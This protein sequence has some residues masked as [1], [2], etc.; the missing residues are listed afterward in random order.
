MIV[1]G[2]MMADKW[3]RIFYQ[4]ALV[5]LCILLPSALIV[6]GCSSQS[7]QVPSLRE[8][9]KAFPVTQDRSWIVAP[10]LKGDEYGLLSYLPFEEYT[11]SNGIPSLTNAMKDIADT[12]HDVT[13]I[14]SAS[15]STVTP[16]VK[17][18]RAVQDIQFNYSLNNDKIILTPTIAAKY[19][20]NVTLDVTVEGVKDKNGN[21]QQ[22][23]KTWIAYIDKNQ[24]VWGNDVFT[25]DKKLNDP[26]T[27][28]TT[29]ANKGGATKQ[30][31]IDNIPSWMTVTPTS[32]IIAP[33]SVLPIKI[34]LDEN[35]A[36]GNYENDL[37]LLTDFG[38]AEKCKQAKLLNNL[39][40]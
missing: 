38:F 20:E 9:P 10:P 35:M 2:I 34:D 11:V 21:Y 29:I 4:R 27:I 8:A 6:G 39:F 19:I 17:L 13:P 33:N 25:L 24:V 26:L 22:S 3:G 7:S 5:C 36:I 18:P 12:S 32:G 14:N 15:F 16:V 1:R 40:K 30:Y 31:T 23:P 37:Q 28:N